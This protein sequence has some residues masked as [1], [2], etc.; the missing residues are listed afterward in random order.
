MECNLCKNNDQ[1]TIEEIAE[2]KNQTFF[3]CK[4]CGLVFQEEPTKTTPDYQEQYQAEFWNTRNIL[5]DIAK[6]NFVNLCYKQPG[7]GKK[8]LEIGFGNGIALERMKEH[9]WNCFG[10]EISKPACENLK[11]NFGIESFCGKFLQFKTQE[12]YD[13]ITMYQVIEHFPGPIEILKK[14]NNLQLPLSMLFLLTPD[15]DNS[16]NF[17]PHWRHFNTRQ[18]HEHLSLFN[19]ESL[20]FLAEKTG[21][22]IQRIGRNKNDQDIW[23]WL[24][25]ESHPTAKP[26]EEKKNGKRN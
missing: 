11:R 25:P 12:K 10:T 16:D 24:K 9:N 8:I 4:K 2:V 1:G 13:L 15:T 26:R 19:E 5:Y 17:S 7:H 23:A 6:A 14:T 20:Q 21:Y 18:E 3:K 22:K